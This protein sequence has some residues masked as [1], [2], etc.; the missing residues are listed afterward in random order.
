M[1][2]Q[3]GERLFKRVTIKIIIPQIDRP[4]VQIIKADPGTFLTKQ[5]ITDLLAAAALEIQDAFP[6]HQYRLVELSANE[7]KF[8]PTGLRIAPQEPNAQ[9]A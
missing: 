1:K 6:T 7:F 4:H 8:V 9:P 2:S 5:H 3:T